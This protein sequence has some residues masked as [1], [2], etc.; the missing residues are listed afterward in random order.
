MMHDNPTIAAYNQYADLYDEEVIE[1]W[2][3]FPKA[4]LE[5]FVTYAPGKHILDV[6]SGSGRDALLLRELGFDVVCQDG[7]KSMVDIT[8]QLGFESHLADFSQLDFPEASFDGIWA[9]T[10]LIHVSKDDAR[11]VIQKL[12][13]L[14][15]PKGVFAIGVIEGKD[16]GM[17]ERKTMPGAVRYFKNYT[18]QELKQMIEPLGF[19]HLYE[20]GYR[21]HTSI[22]INQLYSVDF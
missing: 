8:T 20:R 19:T 1:F 17:V 16:D 9:Y 10:S 5:K 14:L 12:R 13:T 15:K 21:P 3:S 22:Y 11:Q 7:S 4:F 2:D 6:G 18:K